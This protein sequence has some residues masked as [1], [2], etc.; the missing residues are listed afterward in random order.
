MLTSPAVHAINLSR[1]GVP[2]SAVTQAHLGVLGFAGDAQHDKRHHGGPERALSL[3]SLEVVEALAAE[4]H[5]LFP[6]ASGENLTLI[7]VSWSTLLPGTTLAIGPDAVVQISSYCTPC[8]TIA[9]CFL[10]GEFKRISHL[11]EPSRSRLYARVLTG[12]WVTRGDAVA[13][14]DEGGRA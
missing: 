6:G 9:H 14:I 8:K 3:W 7:G 13:V 12:G 5:D 11:V 2:K 10:D 1:G 4:G